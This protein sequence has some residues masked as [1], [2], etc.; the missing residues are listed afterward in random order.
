[1]G[2]DWR[3]KHVNVVCSVAGLSRGIYSQLVPSL[4]GERLCVKEKGSKGVA[5]RKMN[6]NVVG[7]S[8]GIYSQLILVPV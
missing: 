1:M 3:R 7:S 5:Y 8:R 6:V 2:V 4:S